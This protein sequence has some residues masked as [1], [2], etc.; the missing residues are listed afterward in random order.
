VIHPLN[1]HIVETDLV[2]P[3]IQ[4]VGSTSVIKGFPHMVTPVV[5]MTYKRRLAFIRH[6]IQRLI[7]AFGHL[8]KLC[9]ID[10]V[11]G[12]PYLHERTWEKFIDYILSHEDRHWFP[13][14]LRLFF[15]GFWMPTHLE[16]FED[17]V[18][19]WPNYTKVEFPHFNKTGYVP[20]TND[21]RSDELNDYYA[22]DLEL[23]HGLP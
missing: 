3:G 18:H 1:W 8:N 6:P 7:S 21:Y 10:L 16:R 14:T 13:Q 12:N 23:W 4:R 2:I 11:E 22:K 17:I 9:Y 5:A 20:V 15:K 19:V